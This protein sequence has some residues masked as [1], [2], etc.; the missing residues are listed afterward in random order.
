MFNESEVIR[1]LVVLSDVVEGLDEERKI[2]R[3]VFA[4]EPIGWDSG[5]RSVTS[6][7]WFLTG[8]MTRVILSRQSTK[9]SEGFVT[10]QIKIISLL[11]K[12]KIVRNKAAYTAGGSLAKMWSK[13]LPYSPDQ[14]FM[15]AAGEGPTAPLRTDFMSFAVIKAA[16][17][18]K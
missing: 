15:G 3:M 18:P 2:W 17:T 9:I 10:N 4:F 5:S 13:M 11:K 6:D 16:R 12:M 14:E 7:A 1:Q 8:V